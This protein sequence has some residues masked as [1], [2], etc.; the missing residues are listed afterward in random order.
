MVFGVS[1]LNSAPFKTA[2]ALS[3]SVLSI[4]SPC[5]F[6]Y[7]CALSLILVFGVVRTIWFCTKRS[8]VSLN[9]SIYF[10]TFSNIPLSLRM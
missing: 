2:L 4:S 1:N 3:S 6:R 9:G 7:K 8:G 10:I 5:I